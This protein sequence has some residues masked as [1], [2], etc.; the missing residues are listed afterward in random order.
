MLIT[1]NENTKKKN[2]KI[3]YSMS[4]KRNK[5]FEF[6]VLF[7]VL[8]A[9]SKN[10]SNFS[11][12]SMYAAI[13]CSFR[14]IH[15]FKMTKNVSMKFKSKKYESNLIKM[16]S[17][18]SHICINSSFQWIFA[19]SKIKTNRKSKN[20]IYWNKIWFRIKSLKMIAVIFSWCIFQAM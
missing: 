19:L 3:K 11:Y 12:F 16:I 20:K 2:T 1:L 5:L 6:F 18:F 14:R 13:I 10:C 15:A 9:F 4:I 8:T 7:C 17:A